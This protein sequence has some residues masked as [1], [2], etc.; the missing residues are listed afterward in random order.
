MEEPDPMDQPD[1]SWALTLFHRDGRCAKLTP[2]LQRSLWC[3]SL[4]SAAVQETLQTVSPSPSGPSLSI[5]AHLPLILDNV[6]V[7]AS[8][9]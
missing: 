9:S 4:L 2:G 5:L 8:R 3:W 6:S 7:L 1:C